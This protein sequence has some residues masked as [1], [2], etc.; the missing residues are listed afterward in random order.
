MRVD[1]FTALTIYCVVALV[2]LS[3]FIRKLWMKVRRNSYSY[4]AKESVSSGDEVFYGPEY[5]FCAVNPIKTKSAKDAFCFLSSL[6][7]AAGNSV[8]WK[9]LHTYSVY[10]AYPDTNKLYLVDVKKYEITPVGEKPQ[11]I[12]ICEKALYTSSIPPL[13]FSLEPFCEK[14]PILSRIKKHK[15]AKNLAKIGKVALSILWFF[16]ALL[17]YPFTPV[18]WFFDW[19]INYAKNAPKRWS[20]FAKEIKNNR[21]QAK[22]NP[23]KYK[24]KKRLSNLLFILYATIWLVIALCTIDTL[25]YD[26]GEFSFYAVLFGLPYIVIYL[27]CHFG[28][29][30][31]KCV[32]TRWLLLFRNVG[33]I[34]I[35]FFVAATVKYIALPPNSFELTCSTYCVYNN[36]VGNDWK[37]DVVCNDNITINENEKI[38]LHAPPDKLNM[39]FEVTEIDSCSDTAQGSFDFSTKM[40]KWDTISKTEKL[41][42]TEDRGRYSGNTAE[43]EICITIRRIK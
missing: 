19:I 13:G 39:N 31:D 22:N 27:L 12:Y 14:H 11:V 38:I 34:A 7:S 32:I 15:F 35:A 4:K 26:P 8:D 6:K 37:W 36:S 24:N 2:F 5:G 28:Y 21:Q 1:N 10:F 16:V 25:Y 9:R 33:I 30:S 42:V 29:L 41:I 18:F 3:P 40:S 20:D 43:W 17:I 23:I